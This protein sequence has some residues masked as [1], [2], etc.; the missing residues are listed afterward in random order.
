MLKVKALPVA[1]D[2][3]KENNDIIKGIYWQFIKDET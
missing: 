2:M 1:M 3:K